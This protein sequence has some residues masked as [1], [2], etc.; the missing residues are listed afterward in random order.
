MRGERC[1]GWRGLVGNGAGAVVA[2]TG[3]APAR[4][5]NQ[6]DGAGRD[7]DGLTGFGGDV[8]VP[9]SGRGEDVPVRIHGLHEDKRS[10]VT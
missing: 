7:G 6:R 8:R 1:F 4:V 5:H 10:V 3:D 9:N 2:A